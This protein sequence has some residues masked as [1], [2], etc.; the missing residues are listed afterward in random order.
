MRALLH[1]GLG[2]SCLT[3][4]P[5]GA[6]L[7]AKKPASPPS[8]PEK[9]MP[10]ALLIID[11]QPGFAPPQWLIDGIRALI[12]SCPGSPRFTQ[13]PSFHPNNS[14]S[15]SSVGSAAGITESSQSKAHKTRAYATIATVAAPF[16]TAITFCLGNPESSATLDC[17]SPRLLRF[18]RIWCPRRDSRRD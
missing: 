15:S 2:N 11:V 5:V 10:Q 4:P 1:L 9:P 6:G 13:K 16:S 7:P 14:P 17:V 3:S 12:D 18:L 8:L